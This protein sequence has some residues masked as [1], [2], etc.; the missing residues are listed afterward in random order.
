MW[1]FIQNISKL[2]G[3]DVALSPWFQTSQEWYDQWRSLRER[4]IGCV[5]VYDLYVNAVFLHTADIQSASGLAFRGVLYLQLLYLQHFQPSDGCGRWCP[6]GLLIICMR[7][8]TP[9]LVLASVLHAGKILKLLPVNQRLEGTASAA[10]SCPSRTNS[11]AWGWPLQFSL[12]MISNWVI[13]ANMKNT[14]LLS[15]RLT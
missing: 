8:D 12:K 11:G 1:Y 3:S 5:G 14:W 2:C 10:S 7:D 15:G 4:N 9:S 6:A 13:S